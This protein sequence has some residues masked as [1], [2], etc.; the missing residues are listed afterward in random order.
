M[1]FDL[2]DSTDTEQT[3]DLTNGFG[4]PL[5]KIFQQ[6][7]SSTQGFLQTPQTGS[8]IS[9]QPIGDNSPEFKL[10]SFTPLNK[11]DIEPLQTMELKPFNPKFKWI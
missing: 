1:N 4:N 3:P 11:S 5:Q 8:T 2:L 9:L 10:P 6:N 7:Q